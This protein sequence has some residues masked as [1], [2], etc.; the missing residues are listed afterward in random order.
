MWDRSLSIGGTCIHRARGGKGGASARAQ[1]EV[2]GNG[3][4][5]T[6]RPKMD[7]QDSI[8]CEM[9]SI[10]RSGAELA[11]L[12]ILCSSSVSVFSSRSVSPLPR[13]LPLPP[14]RPFLHGSCSCLV[15]SLGG[16]AGLRSA[17]AFFGGDWRIPRS[18]PGARS[19]TPKVCD[20][21]SG[22]RCFLVSVFPVS[23][24][25]AW[26]EDWPSRLG[27]PRRISPWHCLPPAPKI[28][29]LWNFGHNPQQRALM[30]AST[31][32]VRL[33]ASIDGTGAPVHLAA[34]K[35]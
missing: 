27:A 11:S 33:D 6:F 31:D 26:G 22:T 1:S 34:T 8:R 2:W 10:A 18:P 28:R 16:F 3:S 25:P 30:L 13:P 17:P 14:C 19:D 4:L 23:V 29:S 15:S 20:D 35:P 24:G 7:A 21:D 32:L 9:R 5:Q 12:S